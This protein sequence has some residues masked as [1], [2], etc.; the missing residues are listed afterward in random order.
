MNEKRCPSCLKPYG[1]MLEH[2]RKVHPTYGFSAAQLRPFSLIPC[3]ICGT[4]CKSSHGVSTHK[5]KA[6]GVVGASSFPASRR[7]KKPIDWERQRRLEEGA[8]MGAK[9]K[10]QP[11][12][13]QEA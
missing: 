2:I 8:R 10:D 12:N 1:N 13:Q 3:P 11:D 7:Y 4:A 6:H 9:L 5:Q